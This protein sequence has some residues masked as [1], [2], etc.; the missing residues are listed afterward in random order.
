MTHSMRPDHRVLVV[1]DELMIA[2][3]FESILNDSSECTVIGPFARVKRALEA[4]R[5]EPLDAA[6]LDIHLAG[7]P[8]FPVADLLAE[9]GV[10][11]AFVTGY[12]KDVLPPVYRD[13]P[14]LQ[15][16]FRPQTVLAMLGMMIGL[17]IHRE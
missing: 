1:E 7:E 6:L 17:P 10:P 12:A 3:L 16:P 5:N 13:R 2:M 4:A 9:R 15:K 8:V 11:F 14:L